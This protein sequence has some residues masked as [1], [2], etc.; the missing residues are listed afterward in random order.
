MSSGHPCSGRGSF[1]QDDSSLLYVSLSILLPKRPTIIST[2]CDSI[3]LG[4]PREK[5]HILETERNPMLYQA[6]LEG[7]TTYDTSNSSLK[8][9]KAHKNGFRTRSPVWKNPTPI[10]LNSGIFAENMRRAR[11]NHGKNHTCACPDE[12]CHVDVTEEHEFC[13]QCSK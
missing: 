2:N 6:R 8:L 5:Q 10:K 4:Q 1:L 13:S 9:P 7:K 3:L 11:R 12:N